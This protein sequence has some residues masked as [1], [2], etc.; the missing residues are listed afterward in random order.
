MSSAKAVMRASRC[1]KLEGLGALSAL[2]VLNS[3]SSLYGPCSDGAWSLKADVA[4][5]RCA[6]EG[7][8]NEESRM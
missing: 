1:T 7:G 5:V 4:S 8:L 6:T 3:S 2:C